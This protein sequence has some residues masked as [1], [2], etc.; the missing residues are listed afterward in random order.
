M[1][2]DPLSDDMIAPV[3]GSAGYE[4]DEFREMVTEFANK[5]EPRCP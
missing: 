4:A 3:L 2:D 1:L 5:G